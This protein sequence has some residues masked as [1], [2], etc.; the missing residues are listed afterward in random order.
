[1]NN[2]TTK[3]NK[4]IKL[5]F[6]SNNP[7]IDSVLILKAVENIEKIIKKRLA[8]DAFAMDIEIEI[9]MDRKEWIEHHTY[10]YG[11]DLPTWIQADSGRIIRIT[12]DQEKVSTSEE[13]LLIIEHEAVHHI[14]RKHTR[15]HIPAWLDEGIALFLSQELPEDYMNILKQSV[16]KDVCIPF[17][18]LEKPFTEFDRKLKTLAY[19]QSYSMIEYIVETYGWDVIKQM[20]A[21]VARKDKIDSVLMASGLNFYLLEKEWKQRLNGL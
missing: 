8:V 2:F 19:A 17:E 20:I 10:L 6:H 12:M 13:L 14:L 7:F 5:K 4:N 21:A 1:M 11:G 18:M 15:N 16:S 9:F 3:I